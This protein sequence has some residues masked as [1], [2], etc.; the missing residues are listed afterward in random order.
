MDRVGGCCLSGSPAAL[1]ARQLLLGAEGG[2]EAG[3]GWHSGL[4][5]WGFLYLESAGRWDLLLGS[6]TQP[7]GGREAWPNRD[8]DAPLLLHAPA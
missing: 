3:G 6:L 1:P 2:H 8:E 7:A 4:G 5:R